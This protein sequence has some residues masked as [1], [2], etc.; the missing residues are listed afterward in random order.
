MGD[1]Q[2]LLT[3]KS[4]ISST[5]SRPSR[6]R[7][8]KVDP[9]QEN[10]TR[11]RTILFPKQYWM[12]SAKQL[13]I[14]AENTSGSFSVVRNRQPL[15]IV[16]QKVSEAL[17]RKVKMMTQWGMVKKGRKRHR[18]LHLL[19]VLSAVVNLIATLR[20]QTKSRGNLVLYTSFPTRF[21][22][23]L[24][25]RFALPLITPPSAVPRLILGRTLSVAVKPFG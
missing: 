7:I 3:A 13:E 9:N 11:H 24:L 5:R 19:Q 8:T 18:L 10:G 17:R 23:Q 14:T 4:R 2:P 22:K 15:T 12:L 25:P 20:T 1:N 21:Q 16:L 6:K